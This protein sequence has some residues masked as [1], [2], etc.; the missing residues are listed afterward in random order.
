LA[1]G[2][3]EDDGCG[4]CGVEGFDAAGHGDA[5]A[6]IG[7]AF[8]FLGK[9][10]AFVADEES[11]GLAPIDFPGGEQ[12]LVSVVSF[13]NAGGEG[14]NAGDS[15]LGE[16]DREGHPSEN[17]E[18]ERCA[19][20]GTQGFRRIGAGGA[21][22]AGRGCDGPGRAESGGGAEDGAD[23][24][25]ILDACENDEK[26]SAGGSGSADEI[27]E[28][29]FA[30]FN[31]RGD[32]LRMLGIGETFEE[33]VGGAERGEAEF[34]AIDQRGE[35]L[36][37]TLA[38]FAEEHGLDGAAGTQS[39]FDETDAFDADE[40]VFSRQAAAE[41]QTEL[42]EPAIVA[43]GEDRGIV[44][45]LG[46]ASGFAGRSHSVEVSKFSALGVNYANQGDGKLSDKLI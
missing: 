40:S 1:G 30:R 25:G 16:K 18:V 36:A 45:G 7:A 10:G 8:D 23:V 27:V 32:A 21:A 22:D 41:S 11:D 37:V 26:R 17:R 28:R 19:R 12:R 33:A 34:G 20:G 39:L 42:L 4:G 14:A 3:V 2:F 44:G 35:A 43:A 29:S 6:G 31:Q 15:E 5:D 46:V 24:A 9:A 38:G 13:A